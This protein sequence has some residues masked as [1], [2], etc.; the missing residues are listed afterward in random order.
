M[1]VKVWDYLQEYENE[2]DEILSAVDRVFRSGVL[3]LG[4][5]VKNFEKE[6]ADFCETSYCVGV[7]NATNGIFLSLKAL[8]IGAG[9]EVITV[10]NTAVP[11]VS[12]IVQAGARPKFVEIDPNSMLMDVT[13]LEKAISHSTKCIIP[14]HLYGQCVDMTKLM[15]IANKFQIK[16]IEDCSQSHGARH[17]NKRCGSFGDMGIFSFYP[18]KPLG[19]YGDGGA[20]TC[21]KIEYA[22]KLRSLRFYGM[23]GAYYAEEHG[24]NSRLDEVHAEILRFKL[25][26]FESYINARKKIA[27]RYDEILSATDLILP[28]IQQ[29]N[30][31]VYYVYVV[32]HED[33]DLLLLE[34][35]KRDIHLNISYPWPIHTMRGFDYLGMRP[36]DL[37]LTEAA[38][39]KIFSLPMYPTLGRDQ[40]DFVCATLGEILGKKVS[41]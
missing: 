36:G 37:P 23:K 8:G 1:L 35:K 7:D 29:N 28:K 33:R 38:S 11:T 13:L 21:N 17:A 15:N 40:Q 25:K 18:T 3:I 41:L 39:K 6:F 2:R 5:S 31:H 12:A 19:G 30:T 16:V 26:K 22:D 34:L 24:Y 32:S 9:D 14:V 10:A 4:D 20:I 27:T